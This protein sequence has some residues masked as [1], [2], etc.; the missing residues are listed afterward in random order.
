MNGDGGTATNV[1]E[2]QFS[3]FDDDDEED[4]VRLIKV[5]EEEQNEEAIVDKA[6]GMNLPQKSTTGLH[7]VCEATII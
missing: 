1:F 6:R 2:K 3:V 4:E 7:V 5:E